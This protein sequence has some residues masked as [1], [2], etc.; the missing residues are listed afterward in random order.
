MTIGMICCLFFGFLILVGGIA[1]GFSLW[2]DCEKGFG[3]FILIIGIIVGVSMMV[4]SL[5]YSQTES[6]KR[7]LK[8]QK[9]EFG[10]GIERILTVYDINGNIIEQY[11]GKFDVKM[12]QNDQNSYIK[13][14]DENGK[15]H[16]IYYTTGTVI[17]DEK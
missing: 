16:L 11:E 1:W 2:N 17:I 5:L 15:R 7:A 14:D 12:T 10:G 8:D 3:I 9:S 4:G 13:F 6:G